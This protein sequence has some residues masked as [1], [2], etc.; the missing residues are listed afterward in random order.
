MFEE[1]MDQVQPI[2]RKIKQ[3]KIKTVI[4]VVKEQKKDLFE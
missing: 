4:E 3:E 1:L 2:D